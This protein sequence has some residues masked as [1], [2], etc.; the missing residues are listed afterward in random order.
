MPRQRS[1][2]SS[3]QS[4]PL[5]WMELS[6]ASWE[7]IFRRSLMM[8]EGS[9]SPAEYHRMV[10]EKMLAAQQTALLAWGPAATAATLLGPWHKAARGNS[11]RLRRR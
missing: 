7:T 1:R 3:P 10:T 8:M 5:M 4:L 11:R 2:R 6:L 9:C